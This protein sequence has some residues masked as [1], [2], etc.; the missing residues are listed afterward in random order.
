MKEGKT[1]YAGGMT[2]APV[3]KTMAVTHAK[4]GGK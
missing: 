2:S 4:K 3:K 1:V